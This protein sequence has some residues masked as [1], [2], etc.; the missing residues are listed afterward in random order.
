MM[1]KI[2][3]S[4]AIGFAAAL[5]A[6]SAA[7]GGFLEI[8]GAVFAADSNEVTNAWWALPEGIRFTYFAVDGDECTI[9]LEDVLPT[10]AQS[11][12]HVGA[13]A[14]RE[15]LD[16]AW[17]DEDCDMI[18]DE[19]EETTLDWYAQ[20]TLGNVWYF[21]EDT[22]AFGVPPGECDHP[23]DGGCKDGSWEAGED[24]AGVGSIAEQG[25]IML[26]DPT[27]KSGVNYFQEIYEGE[28]LD[29]AKILN[30]KNVNTF[31]YGKVADCVRIKEYSALAPGAVEHKTYCEGLGLVL[32]EENSGGKT[33]FENL[34]DVGPTP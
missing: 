3:S 25:I 11:R 24:V 23:G 8:E 26:T 34:V 20:D 27:G 10:A 15:V 6:Q 16:E 14:V 13:V 19:L 28:A 2:V 5:L 22:T 17:I 31:L 1:G 30:Y 32:V 29:A 12:T 21:G 7:A 18:P 33:V 9:V 4:I